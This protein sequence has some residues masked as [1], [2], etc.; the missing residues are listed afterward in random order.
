MQVCIKYIIPECFADFVYH[1]C[2][3]W[4]VLS[5]NFLTLVF[6]LNLTETSI[7]D[8]MECFRR[9]LPDVQISLKL[10]FLEDHVLPKIRELRAGLGKMNE[11]GGEN[12]HGKHKK[13]ELISANLM[14]Q[15]VRH[16]LTV[17]MQRLT[18]CLPEVQDKMLYKKKRA[19]K[20]V[21]E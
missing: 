11:Q 6:H 20:G 15:P 12:T 1:C 21:E 2:I 3:H 4:L 9:E 16:L 13:E 8:F 17:M 10:H 18:S 19:K 7:D 5:R 14:H